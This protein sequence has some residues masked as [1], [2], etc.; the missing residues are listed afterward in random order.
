MKA[1]AKTENTLPTTPWTP[2]MAVPAAAA[3]DAGLGNENVR[4]EDQ[5]IPR[6]TLLQAMSPEVTAGNEKYID[7]ARPGLLLNSLTSELYK[8]VYCANLNFKTA[9]VVWRK[10]DAGGGFYGE[11]KT[12]DEARQTLAADPEVKD[13]NNY[14]IQ[15]TH[16][17][18]LVLLDENGQ[19]LTPIL[20]DM[21]SSKL[22][23]SRQWNSMPQLREAARF[24]SI[25]TL[26]G[27]P[28]AGP[29]G[30]YFTL[31]IEF[32][33]FADDTLYAQ[34]KQTYADLGFDKH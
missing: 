20:C 29:K 16:T 5:M 18:A 31:G 10:R 2:V 12:E 27:K 3:N 32:A 33:G 13:P 4:A 30:T 14:D 1:Q 9:F 25:W 28:V 7:D 21:S 11:F 24:A 8:A 17:H 26:S 6:L 23:V 15:E 22:K 34:L 19:P